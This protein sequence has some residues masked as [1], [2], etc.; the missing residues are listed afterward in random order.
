MRYYVEESPPITAISPVVNTGALTGDIITLK[1]AGMCYIELHITQGNAAPV[2]ITIE[3]STA[4][5]GTGSKAITEVSNIWSNEDVT[6]S[7]LLTKQTS[8]VSYTTSAAVKNKIV[9]FQV[10]PRTLDLANGFDCIQVKV[11]ASDAANLVQAHYV[12]TSR[13]NDQS[14]IID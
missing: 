3:Q 14:V 1:N 8:A 13:R 7:D 6:A 5:A 2:A 11:A 12:I 4:V 9:V 10:D